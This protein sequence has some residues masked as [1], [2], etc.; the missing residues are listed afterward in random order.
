MKKEI[1]LLPAKSQKGQS[2][3]EFIVSFAFSISIIFLL[4]RVALNYTEGY[5]IHYANFMASRAYL[6]YED[7]SN[8]TEG[9]E[10][11]A[12]NLA[13]QVFNR[14]Y[15]VF[16]GNFNVSY[17]SVSSPHSNLFVGTY[18]EFQRRFSVPMIIGTT[19]E[20][21]LVTESFLGRMPNR[22]ECLARTC[23]AMRILG[24]PECNLANTKHITLA[25]NGC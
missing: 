5:V 19:R 22:A 6:V 12:G 25:D 11:R 7:N 16:D 23:D 3:I 4:L 20:M 1:I 9:G 8:V 14:I 18:A 17:A 2:L 15:P 21:N 10:V 24:V 13:E